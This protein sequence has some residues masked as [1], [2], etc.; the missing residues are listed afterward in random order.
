MLRSPLSRE[1]ESDII[2]TPCRNLRITNPTLRATDDAWS[3][4]MRFL[5]KSTTRH[6]RRPAGTDDR[7]S[8]HASPS[9][10]VLRHLVATRVTPP[11]R[12]ISQQRKTSSSTARSLSSRIAHPLVPTEPPVRLRLPLQPP[13]RACIRQKIRTGRC[14]ATNSCV[15]ALVAAHASG[16]NA[17]MRRSEGGLRD[18]GTVLVTLNGEQRSLVAPVSIR[19]LVRRLSLDEDAV[20]VERNRDI[21]VRGQWPATF[22]QTGDAIEVVQFVGGG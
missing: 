21:V 7:I 6:R 3:G 17:L 16:Y 18:E 2:P 19:D 15:Y 10:A 22:L 20:A 11:S 5:C 12:S 1:L 4:A 9:S 13:D 8:P 14:E